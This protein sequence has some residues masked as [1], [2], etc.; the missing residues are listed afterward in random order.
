MAITNT[1][2]IFGDKWEKNANAFYAETLREGSNTQRWIIGRDGFGSSADFKAHLADTKR[3]LDAGCGN[4]RVPA[5]LSML[6]P[7][8]AKIVGIDLVGTDVARENFKNIPKT[9][10]ETRDLLDDLSELGNFDFIYCQEVL[11]HVTGPER[12]FRNLCSLLASGGEL[13][14]Y[15]CKQKPPVREFVDDYICDRIAAMSYDEAMAQC[16]QITDF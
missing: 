16:Q 13:A 7:E 8:L 1:A 10:F 15:V 12:T 11:H 5:L 4:E 14:I 3:I 2:Q 9:H 6:A